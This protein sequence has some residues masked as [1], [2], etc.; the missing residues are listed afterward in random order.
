MLIYEG[1]IALLNS[2]LV[3]SRKKWCECVQGGTW[4]NNE[5]HCESG[6]CCVCTWYPAETPCPEGQVYL[7]WGVNG[8]CCG[9]V[10][11]QVFDGRVGGFV[12]TLTVADDLCCPG[13]ND[14]S[15][16][17]PYTEFS[18]EIPGTSAGHYR[19]CISRCCV[20]GECSDLYE[21]ECIEQEGTRLTGCC[22]PKGCPQ[23]CCSEDTSGTVQ[24]SVQEQPDCQPPAIIADSCETGCV[25]ACCV[26]GEL[27]ASSPMTQAACD[28]LDGCWQG[29]GTTS[30]DGGTCRSPF[31]A[32]CCEHVTSAGSGLTFTGPRKRRCPEFEGCGFQVT[33]NLTT[34]S[35][36]YVHGLLL[37]S[38]YE[39]C[40]QA[41][42]FATCSDTFYVFPHDCSG[43]FNNLNIEVCW[44]EGTGPETL[45]FQCC[46]SLY[47]LGNCDCDCTTTLIYDGPGCTSGA[48]FEISGPATIDAS[49]TGALV[50]NGT[51][52]APKDCDQ[53]LKLTGTS[54]HGNQIASSI[55][56]SGLKV[57]KTGNGLWRLSAASGYS[58]QLRIL[59]GTLV[60][61]SSVASSGPSPFGQG[62]DALLPQ[63][64]SS[65]ESG[66]A[67]LL[68]DAS[69]GAVDISRGFS[70]AA[71]SGQVAVI[72]ATGAGTSTINAV[73]VRLG[74]S[75]TLQAASIATAV[76]R[77]TWVDS[78]GVMTATSPAVAFTI[79]SSGN[80][81]VVV[82]ETYLPDATTAVNVV[83]GTAR[84]G[85]S[86]VILYTTP[87]SIG[88][89]TLDLDGN[90]QSLSSLTFTTA[91]G[92]ITGGLL[93][94]Y[95]DAGAAS[96]SISGSGNVISSD[97]AL[98]SSLAISG[99]G[100]LLISGVVS[101]SN[102]I[103]KTGTGT[104]RL[105]GTNTYSGTTTINGGTM[106]AE[107]LAAFGTG[108]IV[109]NAGGTLD[110]GGFALTN[111]ITNNGGTVLN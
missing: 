22:N 73:A 78:S 30:C 60:V 70:V 92:T 94:F 9:C 50:L 83:N 47:T 10:P 68:F 55:P 21:H 95:A 66:T 89:A 108:G 54:Q 109:V 111:T 65:A 85:V 36:A 13:C 110:K 14:G 24:C 99:A 52:S 53:T 31:D 46:G 38:P 59:E 29:L 107:N 97:V 15:L 4:C 77:P 45:Y 58:G 43:T 11:D 75:V 103:T 61:A 84:L 18:D 98:D 41:I 3:F 67:A 26:D 8:E 28:E 42:T 17:L 40:T 56:G 90:E 93:A 32:N 79:G 33:V 44:A 81:G 80:A 62:L 91:S 49:G 82:L 20:D 48:A 88:Q 7:R 35:P 102:A 5:C 16:Y 101:G 104:V 39:T 6:D 12:D 2:A 74:R 25:G 69:A 1:A 106:K 100:S 105:S 19:G 87:V 86:Q 37:G 57:E 76:F 64:G 34:S 96:A 63:L 27:H 51:F 71:G 23:P 72:G